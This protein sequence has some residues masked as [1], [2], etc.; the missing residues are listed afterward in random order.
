MTYKNEADSIL[1]DSRKNGNPI[2]FKLDEIPFKGSFE[3]G[4]T[5]ISEGDS[6]AFFVSADSLYKY[7]YKSH[8]AESVPQNATGFKPGTFLRFDIK[9]L[10]VQTEVQ[11]EEEMMLQMSQREKQE[12]KS[13][14]EYI[15][16]KNIEVA[17]DSSGYYLIVREK[18]NGSSVDSGKVITVEYE[19]R[20]LNDNVFDG[21][22]K[23][24][25][26]YR[27]ISGARHVI[28][29]WEKALKHLHA[30]DK[31]TLL[32]PSHLAYGETGIQ[33]PQTGAFLVPPYTPLVFDMEILSVEDAP[34]VSGR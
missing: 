11:A 3:D 18:G 6:A 31:I 1:F 14:E 12:K 17:P 28:A 29:G 33:D 30:G 26:P 19:G 27:F 15:K 25:R 24:G 2:R 13:I 22:K 4:L 21:T 20:F 32:V 16:K 34:P 9:L 8:G 5:N 23:A 10:K 7:L